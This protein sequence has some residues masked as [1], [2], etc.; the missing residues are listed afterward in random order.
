M[1][2]FVRGPA[3]GLLLV[4]GYTALLLVLIL[5]PATINT[6]PIRPL[7]VLPFVLFVPGWVLTAAVFAVGRIALAERLML[8]LGLSMAVAA[9]GG[10]LLNLLPWG[11]RSLPWLAFYTLFIGACLLVAA[12][13]GVPLLPAV[14]YRLPDRH[15]GMQLLIGGVL[16]AGSLGIALLGARA[17]PTATFTQLWA[18]PVA[19]DTIEVGVANDEAAAQTYRVELLT[20]GEIVHA[21]PAIA[22]QPGQQWEETRA[23]AARS[24][25]NV[26][27]YRVEDPTTVYRQAVVRRAP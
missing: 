20:D 24:D 7:L 26:R 9:L 13:R 10:L 1:S 22:L 17:Q 25:I 5:L 11:L 15:T 18:L 23:I 8:S 27:L 3:F 21:W 16:I 12:R 6:G 2:Q 14:A 19:G 4:A